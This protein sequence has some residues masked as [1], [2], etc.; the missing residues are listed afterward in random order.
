ELQVADNAQA[1][2]EKSKSMT[3]FHWAWITFM[4]FATSAPYLLNWSYTPA[5]YHYTWI[6]PSDPE[7]SFA[8]MAWAQQA[9]RGA[10]LFKIKYTALPHAGF[11]VH[12]FFLVCGWLSALVSCEIGI[13]FLAGKAIGVALFFVTFYRYLDYLKVGQIESIAALIVLGISSGL[14]GIVAWLGGTNESAF[15]PADLSIPELTT[16]WSLLWNPLV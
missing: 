6:L 11:L 8:Y 14:G 4:V 10:W 1:V 13:V 16:Y 15:M 7:D 9:A 12:P 3:R 5:G 2:A